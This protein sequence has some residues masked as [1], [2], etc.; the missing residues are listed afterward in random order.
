MDSFLQVL[1]DYATL[2]G[3]FWHYATSFLG[4]VILCLTIL[5]LIVWGLLALLGTPIDPTTG[6][7]VKS[8]QPHQSD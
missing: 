3:V 8:D 1:D 2:V 4:L 7:P 6:K 5:L